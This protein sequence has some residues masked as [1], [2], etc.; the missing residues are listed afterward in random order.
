MLVH[1]RLYLIYSRLR[2]AS[3]EGKPFCTNAKID[4]II[5]LLGSCTERVARASSVWAYSYR[6]YYDFHGDVDPSSSRPGRG[7]HNM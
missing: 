5:S 2:L 4:R 7:H 1:S 3:I 6:L